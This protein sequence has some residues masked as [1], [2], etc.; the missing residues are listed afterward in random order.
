MNAILKTHYALQRIYLQILKMSLKL[1]LKL[2][3]I[4]KTLMKIGNT[5]KCRMDI[6]K[7]SQSFKIQAKQKKTMP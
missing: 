4:K 6:P 3:P 1:K 5:K 2:R 7:K